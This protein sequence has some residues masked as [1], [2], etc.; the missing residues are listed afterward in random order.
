MN[1]YTVEYSDFTV[2]NYLEHNKKREKLIEFSRIKTI[3]ID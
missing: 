1:V 2:R 3:A